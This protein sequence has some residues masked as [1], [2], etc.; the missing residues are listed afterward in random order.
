[1]HQMVDFLRPFF[2]WLLFLHEILD[3]PKS[4]LFSH[5]IIDFVLIIF[6][7]PVIFAA[8]QEERDID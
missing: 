7:M 2:F 4:N 5:P 6:V 3:D 1:M 8:A